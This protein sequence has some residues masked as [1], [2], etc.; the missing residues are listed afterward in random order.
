MTKKS[1]WPAVAEVRHVAVL[2]VDLTGSS[3]LLAS[4]EPH[5]FAEVLEDWFSS[6]C[7]IVRSYGGDI[8]GRP[9]DCVV[10]S[11]PDTI[12]LAPDRAVLAANRIRRASTGMRRPIHIGLHWD[13]CEFLPVREIRTYMSDL[14]SLFGT[15]SWIAARV[16]AA[17]KGGDLLATREFTDAL[18]TCGTWSD[19]GNIEELGRSWSLAECHRIGSHSVAEPESGCS[20]NH[21]HEAAAGWYH[22]IEATVADRVGNASE[23]ILHAREALSSIRDSSDTSE[24]V[25]DLM[26]LTAEA[27][28]NL[29]D[30]EGCLRACDDLM[31]R[32]NASNLA[33]SRANF[34]LAE[35]NCLRGRRN[36]EI[37][38][39]SAAYAVL[40]STPPERQAADCLYYLGTALQ[41]EKGQEEWGKGL[42][43]QA[44]TIYQ[45]FKDSPLADP[46][47][48]VAAR[49]ELALIY[50]F[51]DE[52]LP[53]ATSLLAE[54]LEESS[55]SGY[56]RHLRTILNNLGTIAMQRALFDKAQSYF[57]RAQRLAIAGADL[58]LQALVLRNLGKLWLNRLNVGMP[59]DRAETLKAARDYLDRAARIYEYLG[60]TGMAVD[61]RSLLDALGV[62]DDARKVSHGHFVPLT[63][64]PDDETFDAPP[65]SMDPMARGNW[66]HMKG[67]E[68]EAQEQLTRSLECFQEAMRCK[69]EVGDQA[70]IATSCHM[71]GVIYAKTKDWENAQRHMLESMAIE[72]GEG[73][74]QGLMQSLRDLAIL[75]ADSGA[76]D[77]ATILEE[78][79]SHLGDWLTNRSGPL[80]LSG[81]SVEAL[82]E[83]L[84]SRLSEAIMQASQLLSEATR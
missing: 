30:W 80:N 39:L 56:L 46:L 44:R 72:A 75:S 58:N 1:I 8:K 40:G 32:S 77:Q 6:V 3:A 21:Q 76:T 70:G 14:P 20:L 78:I 36:E 11:W 41:R 61:T 4:S 81:L 59:T 67:R 19:R 15:A 57:R 73:N 22:R 12:E 25:E 38:A 68:Y 33:I 9:G 29:G 79:G 53:R 54:A 50:Q 10:A 34:F 45:R 42:V 13:T 37:E 16:M 66:W 52:D 23:V 28:N 27:C 82:D 2:F 84:R 64:S 83:P 62:P 48:R 63:W 49:L 55:D 26:K 47:E 35:A 51:Y 74:I 18:A 31:R 65:E 69:Q 24:V 17:D 7:G 71:I 60:Y 5:E 43:E